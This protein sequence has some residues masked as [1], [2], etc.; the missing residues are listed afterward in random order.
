MP[1]VCPTQS[2][3]KLEYVLCNRFRNP[4]RIPKLLVTADVDLGQTGR[5]A[6]MVGVGNARGISR[7]RAEIDGQSGVF[8]PDESPSQVIKQSRTEDVRVVPGQTLHL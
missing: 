6:A 8:E 3:G 2:V 7:I 4:K 1:T 5:I